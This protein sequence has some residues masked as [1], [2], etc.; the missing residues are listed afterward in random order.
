MKSRIITALILLALVVPLIFLGGIPYLI[1][2][3]LIIAI[4]THELLNTNKSPIWTQIIGVLLVM[5]CTIYS[6]FSVD[7]P[8]LDFNSLFI[9]LPVLTFFTIAIWDKKRTLM[10]ATYNSV[11]SILM[12]M[13]GNALLEIRTTFGNLNL[14]LYLLITTFAVDIFALFIG[15]KFGKHKLNPR[16]SPKKSVEGAI[17]G[18]VCGLV[19]GSLFAILCPIT[20]AATP[21]ILGIAFEPNFSFINIIA[22]LGLTFVLAIVGQIGDLAFSLIKR[23][24]QIKDFSNILPGHGGFADRID[25]VCFNAITL[26]AILSMYLVL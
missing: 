6:W 16:V 11:A 17:G 23:H 4:A 5:T 9:I 22:I 19:L 13:F 2:V 18:T 14:L 20:H 7:K 12:I 26:V 10:D 1:G 15:C 3:S 24:Y 8:F 21:G 25:S